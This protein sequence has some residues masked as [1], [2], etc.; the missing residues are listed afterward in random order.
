MKTTKEQVTDIAESIHDLVM[1]YQL[2]P[3]DRLKASLLTAIEVKAAELK[4]FI[5]KA[6][7]NDAL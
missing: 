7:E 4:A 1:A 5:K 6:K 2:A 3:N